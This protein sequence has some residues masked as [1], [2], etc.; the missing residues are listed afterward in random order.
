MTLRTDASAPM[1]NTIQTAMNGAATSTSTFMVRTNTRM[2]QFNF[3]NSHTD[4]SGVGITAKTK[5]KKIVL[6]TL[7]SVNCLRNSGQRLVIE[8]RRN[9]YVCTTPRSN[10]MSKLATTYITFF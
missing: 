4:Y 8:F 6:Y 7:L 9:C 10:H 2:G 3:Q 5:K 1:K